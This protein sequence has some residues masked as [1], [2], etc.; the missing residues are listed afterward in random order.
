MSKAKALITR[1]ELD[2]LLELKRKIPKRATFVTKGGPEVV[3]FFQKLSMEQHKLL[4]TAERLLELED[5]MEFLRNGK[6]AGGA[7][8]GVE[9]ILN[10][11]KEFG[12]VTK[13]QSPPEGTH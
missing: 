7:G 3:E 4:N 11:A 2:V 8:L 1:E 5:A 12:F 9:F 6:F 13:K 10:W